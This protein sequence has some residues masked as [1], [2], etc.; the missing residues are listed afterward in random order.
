MF[1]RFFLYRCVHICVL[2]RQQKFLAVVFVTLNIR[3]M[4]TN[5]K[6]ITAKVLLK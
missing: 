1:V 3:D 6:A 5:S 2:C 4:L